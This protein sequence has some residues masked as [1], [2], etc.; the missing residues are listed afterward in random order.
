MIVV[1]W[2]APQ[3]PANRVGGSSALVGGSAAAAGEI[4]AAT[5]VGELREACRPLKGRG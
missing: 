5:I 4:E 3:R 2:G 1:A